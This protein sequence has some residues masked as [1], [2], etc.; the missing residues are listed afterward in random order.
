M[1]IAA[2]EE[3]FSHD[4]P[5]RSTAVRAALEALNAL[6]LTGFMLFYVLLVSEW[7]LT[8]RWGWLQRGFAAV[9]RTAL[10]NY[11]LQAFLIN[12]IFMGWGFGLYDRLGP[13]MTMVLSVP[14]FGVLMVL[15]MWWIARFR[16]GPA[17]WLWR[18]LAY[19]AVQPIR[20]S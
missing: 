8:T 3:L 2:W 17:E 7:S 14:I 5:S 1:T 15:S 10:S 4:L 6:G 11:L 12:L 9:G 13:A 20:N 16:Y 18:T 19:G